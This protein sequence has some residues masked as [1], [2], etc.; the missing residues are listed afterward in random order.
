M[1]QAKLL[2]GNYKTK[3]KKVNEESEETEVA[4]FETEVLKK[5]GGS[6]S[7]VKVFRSLPCNNTSLRIS[8]CSIHHIPV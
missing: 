7:Y 8:R 1:K 6:V 5:L 2:R 4:K 3:S